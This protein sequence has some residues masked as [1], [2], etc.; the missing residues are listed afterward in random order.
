MYC[1]LPTRPS[2]DPKVDLNCR[3]R[4]CP[5]SQKT[6]KNPF[7]TNSI[8]VLPSHH[9]LSNAPLQQGAMVK[10]VCNPNPVSCPDYSECTVQSITPPQSM[11]HKQW[12][13]RHQHIHTTCPSSNPPVAPSNRE[14]VPCFLSPSTTTSPQSHLPPHHYLSCC[15]IRQFKAQG[16]PCPA[17][18]PPL[19]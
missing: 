2:T 4:Q 3:L 11:T 8:T 13:T 19:P 17:C 15:H 6:C 1:T 14:E 12:P 10:A 5:P 16:H 18:S 7:P 9:H